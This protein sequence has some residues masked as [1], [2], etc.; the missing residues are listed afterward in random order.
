VVV[1]GPLLT[2]TGNR[3]PRKNLLLA[4][5]ALFIVGNL[6]SAVS[7]S[8][9]SRD[10]AGRRRPRVHGEHRRVQPRERVRRLAGRPGHRRRQTWP[11][12]TSNGTTEPVRPA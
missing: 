10:A 12:S 9:A 6:I 4:L 2:V 1:G 7:H 11:P 3:L 5:M 8:Y